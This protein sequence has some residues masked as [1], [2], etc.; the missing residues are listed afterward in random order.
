MRRTCP[1]STFLLSIPHCNIIR[2]KKTSAFH[3]VDPQKGF[4]IS[5]SLYLACNDKKAF[6]AS[7]DQSPYTLWS[8]KKVYETLSYLLDNVYIRFGT[9]LYRQIV[10]IHMGT[11]CAPFVSDLLYTATDQENQADVI[12][13]FSSTSWYLGDL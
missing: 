10:G 7:P 4:K 3:R 12:E 9:K 11:N 8:C 2:L 6:F 1:R 5:G 13:T